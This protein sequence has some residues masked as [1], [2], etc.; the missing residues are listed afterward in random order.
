MLTRSGVG[1]IC[2]MRRGRTALISGMHFFVDIYS[3]FFA[4]YLVI[5]G[6]DPIR[7]ALLAAM[8]S[9][10]GNGL[11]PFLGFVADR[12]RGK[13]PVFVGMLVG[14]VCMSSIGL[15]TRYGLL[16]VLMIFGK[17]GISLFH[18]AGSSI[19]GA[20]G[21]AG[22]GRRELSFSVFTFVG[23]IGFSLSQ[24][25]FSLFTARLGSSMS[26]LL[27]APAVAI[28]VVYLLFSPMR[29]DGPE[30]TSRGLGLGAALEQ[31][32]RQ[33]RPLLLLFLIMVF[34]QGF[35]LA[36]GF[37]AARIYADWG[38]GRTVYS[39][40]STILLAAGA[41]GVLAAG[42]LS[43]RHEGRMPPRRLITISCTLFAPFL[44][45][46]MA[47]GS[48]GNLMLSAIFL[49][50]TG[51]TL[52]LGHVANVVMGQRILPSMTA[53][54]SGLLMGFAW[55][56]ASFTQPVAAALSGAIPGLDGL[57]SGFAVIALLPLA[58]AGLSMLLPKDGRPESAR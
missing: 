56:A 16:A 31:L 18:P 33:A 52:N 35:V 11:Q 26:P 14:A 13:S 49:A 55:A 36:L 30:G 27:A 25:A 57:L 32:R 17:V 53:T 51:F 21:G 9:F 5:A 15:T 24:P 43:S 10:V 34:R 2:P 29:V 38:F 46:F 54:V 7:A 8:A 20:A 39:L 22:S 3:G 50:L 19:A 58:A 6:L 41:V 45:A 48:R 4:V 40:A 47:A 42:W 23:T 37:F 44:A 1:Y 12:I 28:A